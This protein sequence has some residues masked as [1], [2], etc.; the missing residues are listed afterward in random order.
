MLVLRI[1]FMIPFVYFCLGMFATIQAIQNLNEQS[2]TSMILI[3]GLFF[4]FS[5]EYITLRKRT[6]ERIRNKLI[7]NLTEEI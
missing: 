2:F 6:V 4:Y 3:N 1:A 5:I 7:K